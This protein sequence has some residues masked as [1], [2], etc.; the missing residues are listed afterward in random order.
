MNVNDVVNSGLHINNKRSIKMANKKKNNDLMENALQAIEDVFSD[1]SV[2]QQETIDR[3]EELV[4]EIRD[5]ISAI[6]ADI[7]NQD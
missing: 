7:Y 6:K 1:I 2:S 5:K 4:A 3:L